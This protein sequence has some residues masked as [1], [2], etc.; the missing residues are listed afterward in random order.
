MLRESSQPKTTAVTL[1]V[2]PLSV[3]STS[4]NVFYLILLLVKAVE[5]A[6]PE[7]AGV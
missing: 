5:K 3:V 1:R 7:M 2:T 6:R 4:D